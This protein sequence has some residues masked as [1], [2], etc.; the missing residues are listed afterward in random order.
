MRYPGFH[1][2]ASVGL[3]G[4]ARV[5]WGCQESAPVRASVLYQFDDAHGIPRDDRLRALDVDDHPEREEA[6]QNT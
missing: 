2:V 6:R 4:V 5:A 3:H 1:E